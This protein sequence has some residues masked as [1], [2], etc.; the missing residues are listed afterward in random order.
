MLGP[1]LCT[2][3]VLNDTYAREQFLLLTVGFGGLGLFLCACLCLVFCV[4]SVL[5]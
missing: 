1:V 4:F 5:A 3:V 2:K